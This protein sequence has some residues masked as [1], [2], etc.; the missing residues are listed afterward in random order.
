[1]EIVLV[2]VG[3]MVAGVL[4]FVGLRAFKGEKGGE[5]DAWRKAG[6]ELGIEFT[7]DTA[8]GDELSLKGWVDGCYVM[9]DLRRESL[10]MIPLVSTRFDVS[11]PEELE[12]ELAV[13]D[14]RCGRDAFWDAAIEVEVPGDDRFS[15]M[16]RVFA[17]DP[18]AAVRFL[19][20]FRRGQ[21]LEI[22]QL[23]GDVSIGPI[24]IGGEMSGVL[25]SAPGIVRRVQGLVE[26]A[27]RISRGWE[28]EAEEAPPG[29]AESAKAG[30]PEVGEPEAA[31]LDQ[32]IAPREEAVELAEE[33]S[34]ADGPSIEEIFA[35]LF[36]EGTSIIDFPLRFSPYDGVRVRWSGVLVEVRP[37]NDGFLFE[38]A[39]GT[40]AVIDLAL[41]GGSLE[42]VRPALVLARLTGDEQENLTRRLGEELVVEGV[43]EG[44][45]GAMREVHLN[46][47]R[48]IW[49]EI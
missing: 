30:I 32:P 34:P 8:I 19:T 18:E 15:E 2:A 16:F 36:A 26:I 45:E 39:A 29:K 9:V 28:R 6:E 49:P 27:T 38:E 35:D 47:G 23:A 40:I 42:G 44:G 20:P 1:V 37:C 7:P 31:D 25:C 14:R 12:E 3:L 41:E 4:L 5:G 21:I 33:P 24:S 13:I 22:D 11:F 10:G 48:I 17:S 46:H 43:L